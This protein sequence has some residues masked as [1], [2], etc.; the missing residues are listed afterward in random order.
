M[1]ACLDSGVLKWLPGFLTVGR[2]QAF[3]ESKDATILTLL[4][5]REFWQ[6]HSLRWPEKLSSPE[7]D[8]NNPSA[9][10][11]GNISNLSVQYLG[12]VFLAHC[13]EWLVPNQLGYCLSP[14]SQVVSVERTCN[15]LIPSGQ[16][17]FAF[18]RAGSMVF[19]DPVLHDLPDQTAWRVTSALG[20]DKGIFPGW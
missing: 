16:T 10:R 5:R 12:E 18:V 2:V 7:R 1:P 15:W 17:S 19:S 8:E 13:L 14:D 9:L 20:T 11:G 6:A 4:A 3:Q